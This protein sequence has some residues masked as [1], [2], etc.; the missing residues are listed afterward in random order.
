MVHQ[1]LSDGTTTFAGPFINLF[2]TVRPPLSDG[3]PIF[4][5]WYPNL[6]QMVHQSLLDGTPIFITVDGSP[7][8]AG[9]YTNL[10]YMVPESFPMIYQSLL[11]DSLIV[12][13]WYNQTSSIDDILLDDYKNSGLLRKSTVKDSFFYILGCA[14]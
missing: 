12:A 2:R 3:T 5:G 10:Y 1:P 14:V 6:C 8:L 13:I 7:I 4:A 11:Y 9:W